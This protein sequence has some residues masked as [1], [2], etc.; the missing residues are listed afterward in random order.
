MDAEVVKILFLF[1]CL[2][3]LLV[4]CYKR[5]M[6]IVTEY[7]KQN[8]IKV[9]ELKSDWKGPDPFILRRSLWQPW[10][11]VQLQNTDGE[12]AQAYVQ[13]GHWLFGILNPIVKVYP[14]DS[15]GKL[16]ERITPQSN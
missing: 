10:Y 7:F 5:S 6:R 2:Y 8:Q 14:V 13:V 12:I 16:I 9:I 3:L 15:D 11:Y 1:L 4:Y